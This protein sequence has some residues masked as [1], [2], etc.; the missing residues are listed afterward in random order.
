[1]KKI[2]LL[3]LTTITLLFY[4]TASGQ[5]ISKKEST[6]IDNILTESSGQ[7]KPKTYIIQ[8]VSIL[9][10]TNSELIKNQ[11]V[12]IENG[13]IQKIG[14]DIQN[15]NATIIDGTGKF[16]MPGLTDMHVHLY[17]NHPLK[18][19]WMILLLINGVT[20]VR[21]MGGEPEKIVLKQK[22]IKNEIL[23]PNL[24]QAG[25]IID[26]KKDEYGLFAVALT[27]E[28]G[29]ELVAQQK[30]SG[31][32]F[33]K[34]YDGL[35]Q[36][37]YEAIMDEAKKQKIDVVG[38]VPNTIAVSKAIESGQ[39]SIE[40]L[41]GYKTWKNWQVSPIE[42]DYAAKT[43]SSETWNCPTFYNL[44]LNGSIEMGKSVITDAKLSELLPDGLIKIW[45][46]RMDGISKEAMEMIE[47]NG[48]NN[49]EVMRTIVLNLYKSNS[50]LIA[51]TD[52]GNLPFLVPGHSLHQELRLMTES[53]IPT[54]EVLK[55][56]TINAALAM[57]KDTEFGSVEVGKRADLLL[58]NSNPLDNI[59][60]LQN[61][62][63]LMIRGIWLSEEE[64]KIITDKIKLAF[65]K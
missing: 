2:R 59:E 20:N 61:R 24:Y 49:T 14:T 41:I 47:R 29:R 10:M 36:E 17:N 3:T 7:F 35:R 33:I 37:V 18:N 52:A 19:T 55:M 60:N 9:T 54:Y 13:I 15:Q 22:I 44:A 27:P 11:S 21:D 46:K 51:G 38:H 31:Y 23:A 40:H 4:L 6:A 30:K 26:G 25:P 65:G 45:G 34:V 50:R 48:A 5:L 1:M 39:K 43:A 32:D 64:I 62:S 42:E 57:N 63:G 28:Q 56:T 16:L 12:L 53:G 58:L 8:N